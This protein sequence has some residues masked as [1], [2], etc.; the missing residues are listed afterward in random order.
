MLYRAYRINEEMIL[1]ELT[2]S[3]ADDISSYALTAVKYFSSKEII[4]GIGNNLFAPK[5]NATRAEAAK[6]IYGAVYR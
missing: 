3:D 6:L 2:F 5:K 4:N 1:P